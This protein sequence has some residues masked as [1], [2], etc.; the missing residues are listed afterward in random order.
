MAILVDSNV[1]LFSIQPDHPWRLES[2]KAIETLLGTELV[3]VLLQNI[4][5]FWNVCTR[6]ADKN[7]LGLSPQET[8]ERLKP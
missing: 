2:V 3:C 7:G 5:E 4:A 1:L 6:P 8:E